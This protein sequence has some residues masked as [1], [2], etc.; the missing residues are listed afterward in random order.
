MNRKKPTIVVIVLSLTIA[1]VTI[2]VARPEKFW[3]PRGRKA[4]PPA[5]PL[6]TPSQS[7]ARADD[8]VQNIRFTLYEEGIKPNEIE[9]Q[10]GLI[11]IVLEDRT[12]KSNG[13]TVVREVGN[14]Q[15][16]VGQVKRSG[17]FW[18]G[19]NEVR[20]APGTYRVSDSGN[21]QHSARLVVIP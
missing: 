8:P 19:R 12:R 14:N 15:T 21:P 2:A 20:L 3:S 9:V 17:D 7:L 1:V 6:P 16:P 5:A 10:K 11:S 13:L 4:P 18:R